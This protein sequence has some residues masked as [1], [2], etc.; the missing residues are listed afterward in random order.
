MSVLPTYCSHFE[1]I[2]CPI[3]AVHFEMKMPT[4]IVCAL[5]ALYL[6]SNLAKPKLSWFWYDEPKLISLRIV[7][8]QCRTKTRL[9]YQLVTSRI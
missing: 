6:R 5:L 9:L 7:I 1:L 4:I 2:K 8:I 3:I